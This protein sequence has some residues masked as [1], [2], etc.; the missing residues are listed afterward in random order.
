MYVL[1]K[2]YRFLGSIVLAL[3]SPLISQ[4]DP[5]EVSFT[6]SSTNKIYSE[7][8]VALLEGAQSR[9]D[10]ALYG[11]DD[12]LIFD[13]IKRAASRGVE[14]RMVLETAASDRNLEGETISAELERSGV[15]VRYVNKTNHHKFAIV[16]EAVAGT[17]SGNWS[18][19]ASYDYDENAVW[20]SDKELVDRY[21]AE[22]SLLWLN[23]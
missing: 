19:N 4:A 12:G 18:V 23:A 6:P 17:G 11:L 20:F 3:S 2:K 22:F 9:V 21:R 8:I 15:D 13:A 14:I 1:W 10:V 16:D 7:Q 5:V